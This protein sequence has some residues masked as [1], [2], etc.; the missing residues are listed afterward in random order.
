[1]ARPRLGR[2][3][4]T[5]KTRPIKALAILLLGAAAFY[6]LFIVRTSFRIRNT[7]YFTLV[8]DAMVSMR[9]AHHLVQGYGLVWNVGDKPVEGFTNPGWLLLMAIVHLLPLAVS[10]ISLVIMIVSALIL[11]GNALVAFKICEA[12]S[13][14]SRFAP[15]LASAITAFYF[16]L[17]FWSLRGME[18]GLLALLVDLGVLVAL[19][20]ARGGRLRVSMLLGMI[21]VL[22]LLVRL[23]SLPQVLLIIIY[24]L[25]SRNLKRGRWAA[26]LAAA[27]LTVV[28]I[29]W[30]QHTYFGD[31]LPNT[32]YQKVA[33][34]S[35]SERIRN[36]ILW[37]N[38]Y[39]TADTLML[40]LFSAMALVCYKGMR[41]REAA[42]L[43]GLFLV[44]CAY[45][46]WVGGDY[47]D[48]QVAAANRFIAQGMP[49]LIILFSLGADRVTSD[50]LATQA[51]WV[52]SRPPIQTTISIGIAAAVLL[53]ISG[54][55]WI[56]W[57]IDNAPM[58]KADVRRV[59][60]GLSIA[61]YTSPD[62]TIAVH[63]AGQIP[64][65]SDRRTIDL[66][67]LND[68]VIAKGPLAGPFYP[69]HDKW[70]YDYSIAYLKPDLIADNWNRLAD[71][72]KDM[73]DYR[74]LASE[75]YVRTDSTLLNVPGLSEPNR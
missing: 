26:P 64:Y 32:Y 44:Q 46:V 60:V 7:L 41:S 42:L 68:P 33:G 9:Y 70:N 47:A 24:V 35:A 56:D 73:A 5:G 62:A 34:A 38:E 20:L 52:D 1:M 53:V 57:G 22:A 2:S 43:A 29:L 28:G 50:L 48:P 23:D 63:A 3:A 19:Q 55:P 4:A 6:A 21:F 17:V 72:M 15:L 58:L 51:P 69:G 30:L 31:F 13:P 37:F 27:I 39:A 74:Q 49:A 66:L 18:V 40:A 54:R 61:K 59:E 12:I 16:P 71:Y 45:S 11:L 10:K 36:G 75:M 14:G 25:S 67:G 8:D 65:Y